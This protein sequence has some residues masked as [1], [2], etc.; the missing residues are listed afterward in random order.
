MIHVYAPDSMDWTGNGQAILDP[1]SCEITEEAGGSYELE[2]QH[3]C[4][5]HGKWLYLVNEA[6]IKA[7]VPVQTIPA[8][9]PLEVAYW[10][11]KDNVTD[12]VIVYAKPLIY[13]YDSAS[14]YAAW[15]A[16]TVYHKGDY[17]SMTT[18]TG[19]KGYRYVGPDGYLTEPPGTTSVW[20]ELSQYDSSRPGKWTGGGKVGQL[21]PGD[22]FIKLGTY[23]ADWIRVRIADGVEGYVKTIYCEFYE[24]ISDAFPARQISEQCFRIYSISVDSE[25][26]TVTV[27]ARH[28]SYD[29]YNIA[30]GQCEVKEATPSTAIMLL[31]A[32]MLIEDVRTI[33]TNVSDYTVTGDYSWNNAINALLDEDIGIVHQLKAKLI[34]DNND[35]FILKN[36]EV[37]NGVSIEYGNNLIGVNWTINT[38]NVITRIVPRAQNADGSTLLLPEQYVDS[39]LI[40]DYA[41]VRMDVLDSGYKVGEKYVDETDTEITLT[42]NDIYRLMRRDCNRRYNLELVDVPDFSLE[43]EFLLLGDTVEYQQYKDLQVL[44]LYDTVTI[45][46]NLLAFASRMQMKGYTWDAINLR[47]IR[48]TFDG[49]FDSIDRSELI[50]RPATPMTSRTQDGCTVSASSVRSYTNDVWMAFDSKLNTSWNIAANDSAPWIQMQMDV[51]ASDIRVFLYS[52]D[53]SNVSHPTAGTVLASNDGATWTQIGTYSGFERV[54]GGLVG[55]VECGNETPYRYIRITISA[56]SAN[57]DLNG[58][59]NIVITG[60]TTY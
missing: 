37:D 2:M 1:I 42:E 22:V 30:V 28:I 44:A 25:E 3:P 59:A 11:V 14:S 47:Y 5:E 41:V 53:T 51:M 32:A 8:L 15:S 40:D 26:M 18:A 38:E 55:I 27:N 12:D 4:D 16:S 9:N 46:H 7:P 48:A 56:W 45:R 19:T 58:I 29:L 57:T 20:Q 43:V 10:K 13:T 17:C 24:G 50:T 54:I 52:R 35:F 21:Y 31:Q 6:I 23:N 49:Y 60:K 36:D 34:R 39:V 33:A